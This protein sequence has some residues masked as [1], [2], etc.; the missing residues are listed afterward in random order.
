MMDRFRD[1]YMDQITCWE[2]ALP[3]LK[4]AGSGLDSSKNNISSPIASPS[5]KRADF[6]DFF[7]YN[8]LQHLVS[9]RNIPFS[10]N[11][12][13]DSISICCRK[14]CPSI[15][16]RV[17]SWP[18]FSGWEYDGPNSRKPQP[19]TSQPVFSKISAKCSTI[20]S[21]RQGRETEIREMLERIMPGYCARAGEAGEEIR[22]LWRKETER[23]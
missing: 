14:N 11:S 19:A 13:P 5:A 1:S 6:T 12:D 22:K 2:R 9:L 10:I 8:L 16:G 7:R 4:E 18:L 21:A 20:S 3:V 17:S 15:S 23:R